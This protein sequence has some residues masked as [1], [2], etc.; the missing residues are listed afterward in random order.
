MPC[1][2]ASGQWTRALTLASTWL[3]VWHAPSGW[4]LPTTLMR[5]LIE[6]SRAEDTDAHM[7]DL[8]D[9]GV[10]AVNEAI[11]TAR[12][13]VGQAGGGDMCRQHGTK[14]ARGNSAGHPAVLILVACAII[15]AHKQLK[16]PKRGCPPIPTCRQHCMPPGEVQHTECQ[17]SMAS[18]QI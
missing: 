11:S 8:S 12:Q 14:G 13:Q 10:A 3:K 7:E 16:E 1:K 17:H 15:G 5:S 9:E 18:C 6:G 2:P 4:T